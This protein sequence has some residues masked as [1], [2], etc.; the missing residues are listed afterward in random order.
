[1][2][3]A[4]NRESPLRNRNNQTVPNLNNLTGPW[5]FDPVWKRVLRHNLEHEKGRVCREE[6]AFLNGTDRRDSETGGSRGSGEGVGAEGRDFR[7]DLLAM[8]EAVCGSGDR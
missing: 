6:E 8:E 1:L 5:F 4:G 7:A 2:A 3:D